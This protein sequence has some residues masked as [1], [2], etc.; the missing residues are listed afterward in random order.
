MME[1]YIRGLIRDE[2]Q[3]QYDLL[4]MTLREED[5]SKIVLAILPELDKLIAKRVIK[6]IHEIVDFIKNN[7]KSE[8]S[9]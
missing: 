7:L 5:A 1:E 4:D 6:H 8:E 3:K 2:L 9:D